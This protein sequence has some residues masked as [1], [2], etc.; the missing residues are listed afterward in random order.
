MATASVMSIRALEARVR[1]ATSAAGRGIQ[2]A[3]L[4][5]AVQAHRLL[6]FPSIAT[7]RAW[8]SPGRPKLVPIS[9]RL[10]PPAGLNRLQSSSPPKKKCNKRKVNIDP[11]G[12]EIFTPSPLLGF[13]TDPVRVLSQDHPDWD[14]SYRVEV[15]L[16]EADLAKAD[17]ASNKL[18]TQHLMSE[19]WLDLG[20]SH[21]D[22]EQ[23]CQCWCRFAR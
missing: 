10:P 4:G 1:R 18:A 11:K 22:V 12:F 20:E 5:D 17:H 21:V 2:A 8:S 14:S 9:R 7:F 19:Q 16:A 13:P 15:A 6:Q 23:A 3:H